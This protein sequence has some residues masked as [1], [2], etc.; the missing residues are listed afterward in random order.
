MN[1]HSLATTAMLGVALVGAA[2]G[3]SACAQDFEKFDGA[4]SA[5]EPDASLDG[6]RP[7]IPASSSDGSVVPPPSIDAGQDSGA[8][9]A[10]C[11]LATSCVTTNTTCIATCEQT[12]TTCESKC[13]ISTKCKKACDD[14]RDSCTSKC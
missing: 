5:L 7:A 10:A 11:T 3:A 1:L 13:G 8:D 2:Q 4:G 14:T 12:K 9:A 6:A